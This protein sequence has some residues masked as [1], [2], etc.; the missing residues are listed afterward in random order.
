MNEMESTVEKVADS[1]WQYIMTLRTRLE[2]L[3]PLVQEFTRKQVVLEE[4]SQ[5]LVAAHRLTAADRIDPDGTIVRA[6]T[7]SK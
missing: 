6:E 4:F 1:D 5:W 3:Q 2:Q 7:E